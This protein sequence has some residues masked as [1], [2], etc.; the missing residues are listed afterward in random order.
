[1]QRVLVGVDAE[2]ASQLAVDWVSQRAERTPLEIT[3]FTEFDM[4]VLDPVEAEARL[5]RTAD[6]VRRTA[7][8]S[9]V[10]TE[11]VERSIVEGLVDRSGEADLLVIGSHPHRRVRS[12]LT[13][14]VPAS[15]V[16]H[17][18]CPTVVVPDDWAPGGHSIVLGVAD[19]GSSDS[20]IAFAAEDALA[21]GVPL[22]AVHAWQLPAA[23]VDAVA[24]LVVTPEELDAYHTELLQKVTDRLG[25]KYRGLE[26]RGTVVEGDGGLI[27]D[28][29]LSDAALLVLGTRRHGPALGTLLG[30]TVQ[31]LLHHGGVPIAIV[32]NIT[33]AEHAEAARQAARA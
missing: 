31:H 2:A 11:L 3:L 25:T 6:R 9:E 14:A 33:P 12:V 5:E 8:G 20:A 10:R 22:D 1:M 28:K 19:D 23:S 18:H 27:L 17:A 13:G 24:T 30:S 15:L 16:T 21:A 4:M 26:V 7:P 32:P 29:H